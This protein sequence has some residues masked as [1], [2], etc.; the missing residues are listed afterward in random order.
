[1]TNWCGRKDYTDICG[2]C[3]FPPWTGGSGRERKMYNELFI[4]SGKNRK[5]LKRSFIFMGVRGLIKIIPLLV[6]YFIIV[7]LLKPVINLG[8]IW[9]LTLILGLIYL[10]YNILEHYL[11]LYCMEMGLRISYDLRMKLGDKLTQLSLGFF[12]YKTLGE[13]N[14]TLSEYVSKLEYFI[15]YQAPFLF[16]AQISVLC[17]MVLF[18]ILDWRMALAS[19][20]VLPLAYLAFA[21]TDRIS[22]QVVREREKSL[23]RLNSTIVEFIQGMTIIKIFNQSSSHFHKFQEAVRDFRDRNIHISR[24]TTLPNIFLL[25]FSSLSIVVLFPVGL[26][27]YFKGVLAMDTF[28]FF[29]IATP[30]FSDS[31]ANYL[32]GYLH[33]K[34]H[35]GQAVEHVMEL[36]NEEAIPQPEKQYSLDKFDIQMEGVSFS[37]ED[38]KVLDDIS[39]HV[40]EKSLTALVGP[41]GSGK[42]TITN[43]I[44]RFWDVDSGTVRIGGLDVRDMGLDNLLSYMSIVFQ[45]VILFDNTVKENIKLGKRNAS[46]S[47]VVTAAKAARC[48]EFIEK[49]PHGYNT[50]IGEGGSKLSEGEKQRISIARAILKDAPIVLLDEATAA[51]DPENESLI[52]E[53]IREMVKS[54]TVLVIAH[55]L[56]TI[57]TAHQIMVLEDGQ[58][59][60][61]GKHSE[62]LELGGLYSKL[63]DQQ[64]KAQNWGFG[65]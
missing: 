22:K 11:Y 45:E 6:L 10:I 25:V 49:L 36:I 46:D 56:Y 16:S 54:K 24:A 18:F 38:Q 15:T 5:N 23:L 59:Q 9:W 58:I 37:Y 43:L 42:T 63:W 8:E 28:I 41:S 62:L 27:L 19:I 48:H 7:E 44:A 12:T 60:E 65:K 35:V 39:F 61:R 57:T 1:M 34:N 14:T 50:V 26:Y 52:Q 64:Q 40:P 2:R 20:T 3:M 53:A 51:L 30:V 33:V 31:L 21:Y 32:Y 17:L 4:L 55:R 47:E 13:L 29:L